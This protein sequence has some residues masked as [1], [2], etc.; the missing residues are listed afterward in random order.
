MIVSCFQRQVVSHC[1]CSN[2]KISVRQQRSFASKFAVQITVCFY[3]FVVYICQAEA[4]FEQ[5]LHFGSLSGFDSSQNLDERNRRDKSRPVFFISKHFY[6]YTSV[7]EAHLTA[8][9]SLNS[10]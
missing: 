2:E 9:F 7:E 4:F 10:L 5:L 6:D 1:G 8:N 3:C